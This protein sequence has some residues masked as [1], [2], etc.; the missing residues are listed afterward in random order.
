[1]NQKEKKIR[2]TLEKMEGFSVV[3][4]VTGLNRPNTGK[5]DDE[6][7]PN[8]CTFR[9]IKLHWSAMECS[10]LLFLLNM[11]CMTS[12]HFVTPNNSLVK[13]SVCPH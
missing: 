1:M 10:T 13:I 11:R 7:L 3:T 12:S 9:A 2:K 4:P 8:I 5:E 6:T